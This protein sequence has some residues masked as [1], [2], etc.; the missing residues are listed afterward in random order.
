MRRMKEPTDTSD[1]L[2]CKFTT[3]YVECKN[4]PIKNFKEFC[5]QGIDL[6]TN[7]DELHS[8]KLTLRRGDEFIPADDILGNQ[9]CEFFNDTVR[10]SSR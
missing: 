5:H 7:N 6:V 1:H 8:I 2:N 3:G 9:N 10:C 4:V